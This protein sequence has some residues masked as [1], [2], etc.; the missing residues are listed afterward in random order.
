MFSW[1][2]LYDNITV[3]NTS[4]LTVS[5]DRADD[6]GMY[7]CDV[8]NPAG[9]ESSTITLNGKISQHNVVL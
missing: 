4:S 8:T 3:A 1:T 5:V 7:R 2:R 9:N 6:G